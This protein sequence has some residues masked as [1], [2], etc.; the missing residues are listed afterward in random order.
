MK[1]KPFIWLLIF[2]CTNGKITTGPSI[3]SRGDENR[4]ISSLY[5]HL[6][7]SNAG[8]LNNINGRSTSQKTFEKNSFWWKPWKTSLRYI[9][10]EDSGSSQAS[11]DDNDTSSG[12]SQ[13]PVDIGARSE[14]GGEGSADIETVDVDYTV[15]NS[16]VAN[17]VTNPTMTDTVTNST[18][19]NTVTN[20]TMVNTVTN[21]TVANTVTKLD[22]VTKSD[23]VASSTMANT[24]TNSTVANTVTNATMT[25]TVTNPT[26]TNSRKQ[27]LQ[28]APIQQQSDEKGIDEIGVKIEDQV[29]A[30]SM[31]KNVAIGV[32]IGIGLLII[33]R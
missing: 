24:V 30:G 8:L 6:V 15:I 3:I 22:T 11:Y 23:T 1:I 27:N 4:T 18:T 31:N 26:N 29:A 32:A 33:I 28:K 20:S 14:G 21:S 7:P 12:D 13:L 16:T 19:T 2:S 17:T 5:F 25:D 10:A 9:A